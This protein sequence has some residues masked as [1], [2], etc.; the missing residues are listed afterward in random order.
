MAD[1]NQTRRE[2]LARE[3]THPRLASPEEQTLL[4]TEAAIRAAGGQVPFR[5]PFAG[6]EFIPQPP[7][8]RHQ[9]IP[10][11]VVAPGLADPSQMML[12]PPMAP[13][14]SLAEKLPVPAAPAAAAPGISFTA[15][16]IEA[17]VSGM[18][19]P[20]VP[21]I[22]QSLAALE[23]ARPVAPE[24]ID[25]LAYV[26]QSITQAGFDP[27]SPL[28]FNLL[29]MGLAGIGGG[30]Q[31]TLAQ[32]ELEQQTAEQ[33]REYTLAQAQA[34]Q[35]LQQQ[36]FRSQLAAQGLLGEKEAAEFEG[37]VFEAEQ[38]A[39][40]VK[41]SYLLQPQLLETEEGKKVKTDV[42]ALPTAKTQTAQLAQGLL[43]QQA[44][45][46]PQATYGAL[47][48][49][50][51][52]AAAVEWAAEQLELPP[53]IG[54]L[55]WTEQDRAKIAQFIQTNEPELFTETVIPYLDVSAA[56]SALGKRPV[57]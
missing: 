55:E 1:Q 30:A 22:E 27:N 35:A 9:Q 17:P 31:A 15:P 53:Q 39:P 54:G 48:S 14:G 32:Q 4:E 50:P 23:E 10:Q 46:N 11:P 12:F 34:Q 52:G 2:K 47:L 42:T 40:S 19:V 18:Q 36:Q 5:L 29:R 25:R 56:V 41:G 49:T 24:P 38:L 43:K 37:R 6:E 57:Q 21:G 33:L 44:L 7:V 20:E 51:K 8:F 45:L 26:L 16:F 28:G 3:M 13:P